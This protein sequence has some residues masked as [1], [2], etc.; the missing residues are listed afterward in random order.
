MN[1]QYR[2]AERLLTFDE[3]RELTLAYGE[4]NVVTKIDSNHT[5]ALDYLRGAIVAL[6]EYRSDSVVKGFR[7]RWNALYDCLAKD[8]WTKKATE[9]AQEPSYG[10]AIPS[11]FSVLQAGPLCLQAISGNDWYA[12]IGW[13]YPG[14]TLPVRSWGRLT[15]FDESKALLWVRPSF[16]YVSHDHIRIASFNVALALRGL[17]Q[18]ILNCVDQY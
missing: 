3:A 17:F 15:T 11:Y 4:A 6:N 12:V 9:E 10:Q 1:T 14:D 18:A 7:D 2:I 8:T 5:P 13:P 16:R